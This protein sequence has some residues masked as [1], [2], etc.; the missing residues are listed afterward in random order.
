MAEYP[1]GAE[2]IKH[3]FKRA[4]IHPLIERDDDARRL[5]FRLTSKS[6]PARRTRKISRGYPAQS[7]GTSFA[8]RWRMA[9]REQDYWI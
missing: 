9:D 4:G 5:A 6:N 8:V 3:Q 7:T 2:A 1:L